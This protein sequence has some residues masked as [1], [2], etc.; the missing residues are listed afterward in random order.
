MDQ[1]PVTSGIVPSE[2]M[3]GLRTIWLGQGK[4]Q[5]PG[6]VLTE[7]GLMTVPKLETTQKFNSKDPT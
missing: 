1:S 4:K 7:Q 2:N 6:E 5:Y 3:V